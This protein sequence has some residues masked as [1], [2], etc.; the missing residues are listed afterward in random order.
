MKASQQMKQSVFD[1]TNGTLAVSYIY[2]SFSG[3]TIS[4]W[5]AMAALVYSLFLIVDKAISMATRFMAWR[6]KRNG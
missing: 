3:W 5:A 2:A 6:A 4:E 1:A